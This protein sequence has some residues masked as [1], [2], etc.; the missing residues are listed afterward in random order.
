MPTN[1]LPLERLGIRTLFL[2]WGAPQG[3]H[4][5]ELISKQLGADVKYIYATTRRGRYIAP[6]KYFAQLL[7]TLVFLIRHRYQLVFV[8]DPPI[9]AVLSVYL[10]SL[11]SNARF[12]ID[13]HTDALQA[14][15]WEWT[16]PLHRF[17]ERRAITTIVTNDQLRELVESWDTHG[18]TLA[19]PPAQFDI[20]QPTVLPDSALNIVM[21][22]TADYDEPVK[23]VLQVAHDLPNVDFY[24]TGDFTRTEYH[25]AILESAPNNVHFTGY[26]RE[27]YFALLDAADVIMCL[28]TEDNTF[29][30]GDNEALWLGKPIITSDWPLLRQYFDRGTIY[31]DNTVES[32]RQAV[33]TM[34]DSLPEYQA[35]IRALQQVR[36]QEW[37]GKANQLVELIQTAFNHRTVQSTL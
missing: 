12:I 22:S 20:A 25:Q 29:L 30:S 21:V 13:S 32:I 10:Y 26:L 24:I 9:F 14:P 11:L 35:E 27:G 37:W 3:S 36:R 5:S 6:S 7:M 34:L 18:F 19:D 2:I 31:V 28:S 23:E 33:M 4:R 1:E 17:L 15:F 16:L 8:Q